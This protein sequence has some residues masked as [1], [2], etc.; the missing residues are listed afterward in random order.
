MSLV[1]YL[2]GMGLDLSRQQIIEIET[3][4]QKSWTFLSSSFKKNCRGCTL[5]G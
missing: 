1:T 3:M 4:M 2:H 5:R